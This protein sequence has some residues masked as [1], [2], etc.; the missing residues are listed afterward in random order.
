MVKIFG[1]ASFRTINC[2][3]LADGLF[4][5]VEDMARRWEYGNKGKKLK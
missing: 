1:K 4:I 2:M 5:E 3:D